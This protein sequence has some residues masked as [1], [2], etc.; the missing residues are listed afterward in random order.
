MPISDR[1][2][3]R[4]GREYQQV[5]EQIKA[6]EV[7]KK[8]ISVKVLAELDRRGT[9][10]IEADGVRVSAVRQTTVAYDPDQALEVLGTR[11]FKK[12]VKTVVDPALIAAAQQAGDLTVEQIA[13]FSSVVPKS[14]YISIGAVSE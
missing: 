13:S 3:A 11:K 4:L 6:L 7:R 2:L 1:K 5:H 9:R 10:A 12:I 8:E 14:A